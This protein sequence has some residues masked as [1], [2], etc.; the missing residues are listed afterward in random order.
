MQWV[1]YAALCSVSVSIYLKWLK[2]RGVDVLNLIAWNY[3]AAFMLT[4]AWFKPSLN[5][6]LNQVPWWHITALGVL[7]PSVFMCLAH[8]LT[9]AG[10][11]RTEMAQRLSVIVSL[12]AAFLIFQE[13]WQWA[14][15]GALI[16]GL[17]AMILLVFSR[18]KMG[19]QASKWLLFVW[20]GY[21]IIDILLKQTSQ[22][23]MKTALVL[24]LIFALAAL[25]SHVYLWLKKRHHFTAT[26]VFAGLGLGVLNFLNIAFYIQAH[27]SL[28]HSPALVFAGMNILVV[29]FG[30]LAGVVF[31]KEHLNARLLAGMILA[32]SSLGLLAYQL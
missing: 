18:H 13:A 32:C 30:V 11:M 8:A 27:K 31:F 24:C 2:H 9:T 19:G 20:L 6:A 1:I 15:G 29:V 28:S 10:M 26:Y 7:L 23:G 17:S 3:I 16:L 14:K 4:L 25:F 5:I 22:M 12:A 21:A